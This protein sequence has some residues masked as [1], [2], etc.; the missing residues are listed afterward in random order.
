MFVNELPAGC[1]IFGKRPKGVPGNSGKRERVIPEAIEQMWPISRGG[2]FF[3]AVA[4]MKMNEVSVHQ[5]ER[6]LPTT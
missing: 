3:T 1:G 4:E 6:R 5:A 2:F